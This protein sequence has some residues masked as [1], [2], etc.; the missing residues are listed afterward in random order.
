MIR[1]LAGVVSLALAWAAA[2]GPAAAQGGAA[3]AAVAQAGG[4]GQTAAA[5]FVRELAGIEEHRLPNGLQIL[6]FPDA[7]STTTLVNITYRVGSR[8]EGAGEYGMA[9]LLEHLV[10]KG[11][12]TWRDITG[13]FARRAMRWNGT[14]SADRTNYFA[15]FNAND[16]TLDF[17]LALEAD[18]MVNSFISKEDLDKEM[19][20]VRNEF[21][22]ADSDPLQVLSQRVMGTAYHWHPYGRATIGVR[23]DIENVPIERL[24]AF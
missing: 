14:T 5:Q 19:P 11:T 13:E 16:E 15:S 9:H 24:R 20:V 17:T 10:F 2:M 18:R 21:E 3:A 7:S 1:V 23:S 8:H 6:L 4:A 22:R 12:P